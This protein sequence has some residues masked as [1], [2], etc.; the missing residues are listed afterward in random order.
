MVRR[1]AR[2]AF[3]L[4][5]PLTVVLAGAVFVLRGRAS[6]KSDRVYKQADLIAKVLAL[7]DSNYVERFDDDKSW[8]LVYDGLKA[9]TGK[10][11]RYS[12]FLTPEESRPF[13]EETHKN[14]VGVGFSA[15]P[16]AP[17]ITV[18]FLF[19]GSPAEKAG[20]VAGDRVVAVAGRP[21]DGL[22]MDEALALVKGEPGTTVRLS[23]R[24]ADGTTSD[25]DLERS[26][27]SQ[28]TV[29]DARLV[30]AERKVGYVYVEGFGD[31]TV[32]ELD[33]AME[34][35]EA[36][37]MAALI[38][39]LRYDGGGLL[40]TCRLFANRFIA[41]GPIVGIKYRDEKEGLTHSADPALCR[42][43]KLPL[44]LLV[45]GQTA[46]AAEIVAGALQDHK[47]AL[48][49]GDRTYGKGVV[50]SIYQLPLDE[51]SGRSATLK[52]TT[53]EYLTPAGRI[54]EKSVTRKQKVLGGLEPD[55]RARLDEA[56]DG[57]LT[58]R[59]RLMHVPEKWRAHHLEATQQ[60]MPELRDRQV[61]AA[62]AVQRGGTPAQDF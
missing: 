10:L 17:A 55:V 19:A 37:G 50:Q 30:D 3:F 15:L 42:W 12:V 22:A 46:S 56:H 62:L 51:S 21:L 6:E 29:L 14:Y 47:R 25:V 31:S 54:I 57:E 5:L 18:D 61:D 44:A 9:S 35:L 7:V 16:G 36:Q 32:D 60:T 45:N 34:R 28:P 39:D 24:R 53:A 26:R 8:Q 23:V 59:I 40:D 13:A 11:D 33:A 1:D 41:A 52:I 20:M 48:L 27:I 43:P 58:R 2:N 49:V 4:S 38:I